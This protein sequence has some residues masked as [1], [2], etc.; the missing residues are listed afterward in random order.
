MLQI[1]PQL[2]H[3]DPWM[4]SITT[5]Q[6]SDNKYR[7]LSINSQGSLVT[8]C[9]KDQKRQFSTLKYVLHAYWFWTNVIIS[10]LGTHSVYFFWHTL[11]VLAVNTLKTSATARSITITWWQQCLKD[12]RHGREDVFCCFFKAKFCRVYDANFQH[13]NKYSTLIDFG[14][15]S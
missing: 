7:P 5:G 10:G 12:S 13:R 11:Y 3:T 2:N 6:D 9:A 4:T 8:A 1:L 15:M 14:Q